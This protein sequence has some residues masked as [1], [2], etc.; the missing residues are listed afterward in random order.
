M[1]ITNSITAIALFFAGLSFTE[2]ITFVAGLL[3]VGLALFANIASIR[4]H[5]SQR[6]LAEKQLEK[7][8]EDEAKQ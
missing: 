4:K 5:N 1:K 3:A 8:K 2:Q 7:M 6:K